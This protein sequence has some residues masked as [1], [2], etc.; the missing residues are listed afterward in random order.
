MLKGVRIRI[1]PNKIQQNLIANTFG[2]CRLVYNKGLA[3][4]KE[5]YETTSV[6]IGYK[7]TNAMLTNLKKEDDFAFLKNV[8]AISLQQSLK[9][10]DR[11]YK[12]FFKH[13]G[14]YPHFK[15]KKETFKASSQLCNCCGYQNKAVKN[16]NVREWTCPVCG[17]YHD[18]DNNAA[19]NIL[20]KALE[21]VGF[22]AA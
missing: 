22:V 20:D 17:T 15:S 6:G 16:L 21:M 2:C 14:G 12:N 10:L 9:D 13:L 8:D 5:T 4:R 3:L 1:Y 18:R 19:D 7:E 11:A